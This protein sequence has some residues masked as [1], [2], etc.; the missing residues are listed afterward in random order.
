MATQTRINTFINRATTKCRE[1]ATL[2]IGSIDHYQ[3]YQ[4]RV[5]KELMHKLYEG[6]QFIKLLRTSDKGGLTS[7]EQDELIDFYWKWLELNPVHAVSYANYTMPIRNETV[8]LPAGSYATTEQLNA[9]INTRINRYNYLLQLINN[10]SIPDLA[11]AFPEN[12]WDNLNETNAVVFDDDARLHTHGNKSVLD[13]FTADHLTLLTAVQTHMNAVGQ[14]SS[15]HITQAEREAWNAKVS[16]SQL[17]TALANYSQ[18][19]HTHTIAQVVGLESVLNQ[20]LSDLEGIDP[21]PGE[22][23]RTPEFQLTG[24][25]VLQYRYDEEDDWVDLGD[26]TGPEGAGFEVDARGLAPDRLNSTYDGMDE[27]FTFLDE[28]TGYIYWRKP[29]GGPATSP[30]GWSLPQ[31]FTGEDGWSPVFGAAELSSTRV[32]LRLIDWVGGS[33][34]NKPATTSGGLPLYVGASGFTNQSQFAINIKGPQGF[35]T[36]PII[37]AA[38]AIGDRADYNGEAEG[39]IFL[40]TDV[41][42][43]TIFIK[44]SDDSGDWS[45]ELPWQGESGGGSGSTGLTNVE[46]DTSGS[47]IELS[48]ANAKERMFYSSD[49]IT[50]NAEVEI[51][52]AA[53]ALAIR[54][55]RFEVDDAN[56]DITFPDNVK[57]V[58]GTA[59][60]ED[61]GAHIWTSFSAG[62]YIVLGTYDE[63]SDEWLLQ[64]I[65]NY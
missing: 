46:V 23:G 45:Q 44:L 57:F 58:P 56:I 52:D 36:G 63:T 17:N 3:G 39:F 2:L 31:K 4:D 30:S 16:T 48:M 8:N 19:G 27:N 12:F 29:S 59:G 10:L 21:A 62:K 47:T 18:T 28:D 25:G 33:T 64:L 35:G 37:R 61:Q 24:S 5:S 20:I 7:K 51:T 41:T 65:G 9:E 14:A 43:Q 11:D 40:R 6:R 50:A 34:P 42:P 15:P 13:Q 1:I 54:A 60:W 49:I 55:W 53:L 26:L 38:G 32:A 22:D